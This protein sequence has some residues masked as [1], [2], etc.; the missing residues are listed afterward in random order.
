LENLG[1]SPGLLIVQII[2]FIIVFLALNAW[3]YRPMLNMLESR[4]QKIAQGLEDARVAAEARANAEKEAAKIIA[5]AQTEAS[6]VVRDATERAATAGQDVK[7]A[8]EAEAAK[9][10]EAAVA[11]A[12]I[13]RNRILGDLRSQV[14]SLA[15][16]AANKL[17]GEALDA[18]K[19]HALLDEFFS[20]VKSGKLV[21][22]EGAD[23]KGE[24]AQVTSALPLNPEEEQAVRRDIL[25]KTGAR[26][27]TFHVDPAIL[28]GLVIRVGDKVLDSSVAGKLEGLRQSLR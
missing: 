16:A 13:E 15:I 6:K 9:A 5:D 3:V 27:V 28:G 2:S 12:E 19:Q 11:E 10:R 22:L 17:V 7:A 14:A 20:G 21:V 24:S 26:D 23:F 4:R 25:S 8:V 1:I 18:K